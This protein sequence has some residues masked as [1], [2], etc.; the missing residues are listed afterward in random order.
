[1]SNKTYKEVAKDIEK[2][3]AK[4]SGAAEQSHY[5]DSSRNVAVCLD[6]KELSQALKNFDQDVR[7]CFKLLINLNHFEPG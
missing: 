1:M 5:V 2:K 4:G 3:N 7:R 6:S